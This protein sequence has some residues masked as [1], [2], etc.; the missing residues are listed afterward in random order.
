VR[1]ALRRFP[2]ERALQLAIAVAIV[3]SVLAAGAILSWIEPARTLRWVALIAVL[4]LALAYAYRSEGGPVP[5]G[6][7]AAA[8][9]LLGLAALSAAWSPVP[10]LTL[11]RTAALAILFAAC[12]ALAYAAAGRTEAIRRLLYGV[13]AGSGAVAVGGLLV[14]L[15]EH[16][17]A[18]APATTSLPARYQGLGGGP[19]TA[20]MVLAVGTP[21]AAYALVDSQSRLGRAVSLGLLALLVG[22]IVAS[23]SRGALTAA[24]SGLLAFAVLAARSLRSRGLA[25]AGVTAAFALAVLVMQLPGPAEAAGTQPSPP[26]ASDSVPNPAPGYLD[27][28]KVLRLQDDVGRPPWGVAATDKESRTLLGTSGRSEAWEGALEQAAERPLL[29]YGFGTEHRVF[30]DRYVGFNSNAVENSYIGLFLQLGLAGVAAFVVLVVVL[31]RPAAA[32]LRPLDARVARVIAASAGG[33]VVG[34]IL[35]VAQSYIYAVGNN[36]TAAVWICASLLAATRGLA[37]PVAARRYGVPR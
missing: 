30:V 3:T 35:A 25:G 22:S 31:A 17:R 9:T 29:G 36:A 8:L 19:D 27:A 11:A 21:I 20:T 18:V 15:F 4:A 23:G 33:L 16:E 14:L 28:N 26:A 6:I 37:D 34:L 7:W 13:L 1:D 5:R 2:L 10:G 24:F 32:A 12:G